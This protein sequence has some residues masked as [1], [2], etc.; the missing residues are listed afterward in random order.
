[1][2]KTAVKTPKPTAK[3]S[4]QSKTKAIGDVVEKANQEALKKLKALKL[5]EQLQADIEWC[6]GSYSFDKNPVGLYTTAER[7]LK[8][9]MAQKEKNAKSVPAKLITDLEK[10]VSA[11]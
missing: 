1:M 11:G 3:V 2:G 4:G 6:L 10:V 8:V 9:F 7:A 5:D